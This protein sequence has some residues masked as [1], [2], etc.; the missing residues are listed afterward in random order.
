METKQFTRKPFPVAAVQVTLQNIEEVAEWSNG[1]I[2]YRPT[3]M[4]GTTTD[5]PVIRLKGQGEGNRGKDF[6]A[7]LGFW[8]VELKGSFRSYKPA[9]FE[10]TFDEILPPTVEVVIDRKPVSDECDGSQCQSD[11]DE[12]STPGL[13]QISKGFNALTSNSGSDN[14]DGVVDAQEQVSKNCVPI[15]SGTHVYEAN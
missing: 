1:T 11:T 2:E 7:A 9:V 3:R 8:V 4:M 12:E 14:Y 13:L 15:T 6:E 10:A 5:L